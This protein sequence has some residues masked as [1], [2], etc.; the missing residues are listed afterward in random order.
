MSRRR[1]YFH[2][3]PLI[4]AVLWA[5]SPAIAQQ[6]DPL[7]PSLLTP[8]IDGDRRQPPGFRPASR[9]PAAQ[10]ERFRRPPASGAGKSGFVSTNIPQQKAKTAPAR[11]AAAP[12]PL[13]LP[14]NASPQAR[15]AALQDAAQATGS[16]GIESPNFRP[17]PRRNP[18]DETPFD[19]LGWRAG[20]FLIKPAVELSGGYDSN[21]ARAPAGS[22]GAQFYVIAPEL[23]IR[24]D[25]SRHALN[26]DLRGSYTGYQSSDASDRPSIDARIT[27]RVDVQRDTSV[28]LEGRLLVGTDNPNSLNVQGNLT[29]L[30]AYTTIGGTAGVTQRFNRVEV[31]AKATAD[32]SS[33]QSSTFT[34]GATESNADRDYNQ[35]GGQLR[36]SY[37]TL[38]GV[39]PFVEVA[40]DTRTHDLRLDRSGLQRDSN[41]ITYRA[42]TSFDLPQRLTGEVS[43]G[44]TT[45]DYKDAALASV[46]G[47]VFDS[48]LAWSATP[49]TTATLTAR[50][51]VNELVLP[52]MSGYL[53]R[54]VG[55]QID[56]AFRR[57]L[58][59]TFKAGAGFDAY[60]SIGRNDTRYL[61]AAGF[62]YKATREV[63]IK[64][65]VRREW[66]T[67]SLPGQDYSADIFT[68]GVRLA[69]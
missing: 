18:V 12:A 24:S 19:P 48:S 10:A 28:D 3:V 44:Y 50:S 25:W 42:G 69:R 16:V 54:D 53:S 37:E 57:Y 68:L 43:L 46:G 5:S 59:A 34:T 62:T 58:V 66:L 23:L 33:F 1:P 7:V 39:K 9:T 22:R 65:E 47:F 30:P 27:G 51:T 49:L 35:Y 67:S 8:Q 11:A 38:P 26:A 60:D 45:R 29:R 61:L 55:V 20:A 17:R 63:H 14:S 64:G 13:A 15:R 2:A 32:R 40:G 4:L 6:D 56:H 52:G 41:G 21:P 31:S 36:G